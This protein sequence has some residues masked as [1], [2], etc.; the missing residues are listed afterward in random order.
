[1][2]CICGDPFFPAPPTFIVLLNVSGG[3]WRPWGFAIP[4]PFGSPPP[5]RDSKKKKWTCDSNS[6]KPCPFFPSVGSL[7]GAV[8]D[9]ILFSPFLHYFFHKPPPFQKKAPPPLFNF[10]F[11]LF[12]VLSLTPWFG[13]WWT[14]SSFCLFFSSPPA[15]FW[16][17]GTVL[18][19]PCRV[20]DFDFVLPPPL[21][22]FFGAAPQVLP[23]VLGWTNQRAHGDIWYMVAIPS[24][25]KKINFLLSLHPESSLPSFF[26]TVVL[27]LLQ[28]GDCHLP[29]PCLVPPSH[30]RP[31]FFP[32]WNDL[33]AGPFVNVKNFLPFLFAHPPLDN[34]S[35]IPCVLNKPPPGWPTAIF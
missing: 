13:G 32:P 23:F 21:R 29:P 12:S 17:D 35:F 34:R 6:L 26:T 16:A 4:V 15:T 28:L 8:V 19:T 25:I 24:N 3:G 22:T 7:P 11:V 1:L 14:A 9:Q 30:S 18:Q 31:V 10:R 20:D 2:F 5:K 27:S 33:T